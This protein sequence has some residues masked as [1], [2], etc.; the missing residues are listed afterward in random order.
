MVGR[1]LEDYR[2]GPLLNAR[3]M[4]Y[5][6]HIHVYEQMKRC[7]PVPANSKTLSWSSIATAA[8]SA[9]EVVHRPPLHHRTTPTD[10]SRCRRTNLLYSSTSSPSSPVHFCMLLSSIPFF[11]FSFSFLVLFSTS[12]STSF[13][14]RIASAFRTRTNYLHK[15]F[16]PPTLYLAV[17][18]IYNNWR[19]QE[20]T[21][22][23]DH[24]VGKTGRK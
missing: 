17:T 1:A 6:V 14:H 16:S 9:T 18:N 20:L 3:M 13:F 15:I 11:F 12:A 24:Y 8:A 23:V 22:D 10:I 19:T 5:Y 2:P 21:F 4:Y 7:Q